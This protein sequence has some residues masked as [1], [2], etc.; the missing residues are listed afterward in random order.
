MLALLDLSK[1]FLIKIDA[2]YDDIGVVLI[3]GVHPIAYI[4]KTLSS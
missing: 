1:K 4:S 2:S 3:Q